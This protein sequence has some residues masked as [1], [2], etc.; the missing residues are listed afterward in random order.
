MDHA[1]ARINGV[2]LRRFRAWDMRPEF[3]H[4]DAFFNAKNSWARGFFPQLAEK[5]PFRDSNTFNW[6]VGP[7]L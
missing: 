7:S 1:L 5:A 3:I 4:A 2:V 6:T